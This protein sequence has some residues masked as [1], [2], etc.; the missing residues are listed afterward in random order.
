MVNIRQGARQDDFDGW[1]LT[2]QG[3]QHLNSEATLDLVEPL[4]TTDR[5]P[6]TSETLSIAL[7]VVHAGIPRRLALKASSLFSTVTLGD[8]DGGSQDAPALKDVATLTAFPVQLAY[9]KTVHLAQV[10]W[11]SGTLASDIHSLFGLTFTHTHTLSLFPFSN[12]CCSVS[13]SLASA[14]LWA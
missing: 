5:R 2:L 3:P 13:P 6:C 9:A 11:M 4:V 1:S 12:L 10:G 14:H 8:E 7:L